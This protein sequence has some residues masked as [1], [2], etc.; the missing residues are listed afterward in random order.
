MRKC[1]HSFRV[2][3]FC[4]PSKENKYPDITFKCRKCGFYKTRKMTEKESQKYNKERIEQDKEI[5]QIHKLWWKFSK[6]FGDDLNGWKYKG[7]DFICRVEKFAKTNKEIII[8]RCDDSGHTGSI[9][10]LIP[11]K[12]FKTYMGTTVIYIPQCFGSPSEFFLYPHHKS[13]LIA[14]LEKCRF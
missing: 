13:D 10:V 11:H 9:L 7:Y 5:K 12:G 3:S 2:Q 14:K 6:K 4:Y 8:T 1:K